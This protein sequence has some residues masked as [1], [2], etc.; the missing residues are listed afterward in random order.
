MT[1]RNET[2]KPSPSYERHLAA[3]KAGEIT[4]TNIIGIRK[5]LNGANR[6]ANGWT[7]G[8]C[9]P[10]GTL[11]QAYAL[12]EAIREYKPKVAGELHET[13]LTLLRNKRYSKRWTHTQQWEIDQCIGF[14]LVDFES[15]NRECYHIPVYQVM[16]PVKAGFTFYN[17][18]WQSG[19]NGP[20]VI[21]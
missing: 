11:E 19:G 9:T 17:I 2:Q 13:G 5:L 16:T 8:R 21:G 14:R 15:I 10:L 18:P 4:K 6:R 7:V 1:H 20:E 3:I 12:V